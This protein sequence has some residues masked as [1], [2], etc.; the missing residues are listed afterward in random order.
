MP[1]TGNLTNGIFLAGQG[2]VE[3]SYKWPTLALAPRFGFAYDFSGDQKLILR[4]ATGLFFDRPDGNSIYGLVANPPNASTV[5]INFG[6]LQN[7]TSTIAGPPALTVYEYDS[8]LP[9][10]VQ[11]STGVQMAL[12][13][14]S[15]LDVCTSA[16][17]A[18]TWARPSTST[19]WTSAPLTWRRTRTATLSSTVPGG[20]AVATDLM[21]GYRG[22]G[23]INQFWGRGWNKYHSIQT[24]FNRRFSNGVSFGLNWTLGL[25]NNTN[26]GARLEHGTDGSLHY[27]A[28][29]DEADELLGRGQLQ[30]HTFKGNFVWDLPDIERP[31]AAP[32]RRCS[33]RSPTTGSCRA[34]TPAS[35]ATATASATATRAAAAT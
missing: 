8:K 7:L 19:R 9:S 33:R 2:I 10:S 25:V 26:S 35:P 1:N 13:W 15:V 28:D 12:P 6:Q 27:R 22:Y 4:G 11:W 16:S 29:Q 30:R 23:Q 14:S 17:T 5:T 24:T 20:N 18:T 32:P 21:R 3:T 34:S 31:R